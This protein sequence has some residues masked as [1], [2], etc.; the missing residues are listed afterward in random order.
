MVQYSTEN[1]AVCNTAAE[2]CTRRHIS[3][4]AYSLHTGPGPARARRSSS[5]WMPASMTTRAMSLFCAVTVIAAMPV[6][7]PS[8]SISVEFS[9]AV[10]PAFTNKA[11]DLRAVE[12]AG[13]IVLARQLN[14]QTAVLSSH[15][16]EI[17]AHRR[18]P[19]A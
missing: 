13:R 4:A 10:D 2:G 17:A 11:E 18:L 12:M 16:V 8:G 14:V 7:S 1:H 19:P 3:T 5:G 6:S 9:A 15:V